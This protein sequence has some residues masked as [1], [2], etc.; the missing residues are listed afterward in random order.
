MR[1]LLGFVSNKRL[2]E[3]LYASSWVAHISKYLAY[4]SGIDGLAL[5]E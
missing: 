5:V 4:S 1:K 2:K 3:L